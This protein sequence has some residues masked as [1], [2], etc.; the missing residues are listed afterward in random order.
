M[1]I[2]KYLLVH[3]S[4]KEE[5]LLALCL[6]SLR[7]FVCVCYQ[8]YA[9]TTWLSLTELVGEVKQGAHY[10]LRKIHIQYIQI[11]WFCNVNCYFSF[12]PHLIPFLT[13]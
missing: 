7:L 5:V 13:A 12:S 9:N 10:I 6:G 2:Y 3:Y 8:G 11:Y 4:A 1:E